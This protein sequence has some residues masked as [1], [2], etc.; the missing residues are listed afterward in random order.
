LYLKITYS[1]QHQF[2]LY[3]GFFNAQANGSGE[4]IQAIS[5]GL[6][7]TV[8]IKGKPSKLSSLKERMNGIL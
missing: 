8:R 6:Q 1:S 5:E 7:P 2:F 3:V 4:D